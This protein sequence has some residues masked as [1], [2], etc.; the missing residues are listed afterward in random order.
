MNESQTQVETVTFDISSD[1]EE[2]RPQM[3]HTEQGSI[4]S[5]S[6]WVSLCDMLSAA[7]TST[8]KTMWHCQEALSW[9]FCGVSEWKGYNAHENAKDS[10][11][12]GQKLNSD[13]GAGIINYIWSHVSISSS[14]DLETRLTMFLFTTFCEFRI[15]NNAIPI[16]SG[17][18]DLCRIKNRTQDWAI[19]R[20]GKW[21]GNEISDVTNAPSWRAD[22]K[23]RHN[24][25]VNC[26]SASTW[27]LPRFEFSGWILS[28]NQWNVKLKLI[29]I[30]SPFWILLRLLCL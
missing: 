21:A 10:G 15:S 1:L 17:F 12:G 19:V 18:N 13:Q 25:F 6:C 27:I 11:P 14:W 29:L 30:V 3:Q 5:A 4:V 16:L 2:N 26:S 24:N 20:T 23:W 9:E 28:A 7:S 22:G 8:R